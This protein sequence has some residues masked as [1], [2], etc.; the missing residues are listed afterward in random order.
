[1]ERI[2]R[3][4]QGRVLQPTDRRANALCGDA[5]SEHNVA[6]CVPRLTQRRI[7]QPTDRRPNA[8]CG[9]TGGERNVAERIPRLTQRR[10][11]QPTDGRPNALR[12]DAV[13]AH[14]L[15]PL[16]PRAQEVAVGDALAHRTEDVGRLRRLLTV[17]DH[18][19]EGAGQAGVEDAARRDAQRLTRLGAR[20]C[21]IG[22]SDVAAR[23][24]AIRQPRDR[25]LQAA[26]GIHLLV[27]PCHPRAVAP[28]HKRRHA[29]LGGAAQELLLEHKPR[30]HQPLGKRVA[31]LE[32]GDGL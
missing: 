2:P 27:D 23:Q 24:V 26:E 18:G 10:I 17:A 28:R 25:A 11:L 6:E 1:M 29:L 32:G 8:L 19:C 13:N 9:E 31:A 12:R 4:T 30:H 16:I 22:P 5:S 3:L 7:L 20:G 15:P 21:V 14:K